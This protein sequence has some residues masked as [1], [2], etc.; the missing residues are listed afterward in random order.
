M[1]KFHRRLDIVNKMLCK[2]NVA[3]ITE[4]E[5]E[6]KWEE[7][8]RDL[9]PGEARKSLDDF[10]HESHINRIIEGYCDRNVSESNPELTGRFLEWLDNGDCTDVKD[11][12]LFGR[13]EKLFDE[14]ERTEESD[15][16]VRDQQRMDDLW[17]HIREREQQKAVM[18][19]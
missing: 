8:N 11:A 12:A 18:T 17:R 5:I 9:A 16:P 14:N 3:P 10:W 6:Q 2:Y 15:D 13:F 7:A 19:S 4:Q 1:D